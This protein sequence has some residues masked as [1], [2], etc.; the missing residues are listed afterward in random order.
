MGNYFFYF[1]NLNSSQWHHHSFLQS[2]PTI[3]LSKWKPRE[4]RP[5]AQASHSW[6][7]EINFKHRQGKWVQS[8]PHQSHSSSH[9]RRWLRN[10][11]GAG[12]MMSLAYKVTICPNPA[13]QSRLKSME[14][15][16]RTRVQVRLKLRR[17]LGKI[18]RQ[19]I[20]MNYLTT[21]HGPIE[22]RRLRC[23]RTSPRPSVRQKLLLLKRTQ[24]SRRSQRPVQMITQLR[25]I[26]SCLT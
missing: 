20:P 4:C 19:P 10:L 2:K 26:R 9:P 6:S 14:W 22:C 1:Y 17:S 7:H 25:Q 21:N 13:L 23:T 16:Q 15:L 12:Q 11:Q 8:G 5:S 3:S 18:I 24:R